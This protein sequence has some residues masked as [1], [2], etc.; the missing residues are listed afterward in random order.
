[1]V[2]YGVCGELEPRQRA[3]GDG[4]GLAGDEKQLAVV[5]PRHVAARVGGR[6]AGERARREDA[7]ELAALH[8]D[9]GCWGI[10]QQTMSKLA[11]ESRAAVRVI[12]AARIDLAATHVAAYPGPGTT[13]GR[14]VP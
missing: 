10:C 2:R 9:A 6:D 14:R 11:C 1:M 12:L 13:G 3:Y 5:V 8:D 7:R 4:H